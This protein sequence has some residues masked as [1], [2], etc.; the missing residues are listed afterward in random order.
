MD[1]F[2][3]IRK[4]FADLTPKRSDVTLGIGDDGAILQLAPGHELV[5]T[6]DTLVERHHFY[7]DAAP[8]DIGWKS[9]ATGL[10]D[11]AAMGADPHSC[12]LAITLPEADA[13]WLK[14]FSRGFRDLAVQHGVSLIGGNTT[15]GPA[16]ITVTCFG[17]IQAGRAVRRAG[18]KNG[19]IV[20]VTGT[21]GDAALGLR[22][23]Q[24]RMQA[25]S[26][27]RRL[28]RRKSDPPQGLDPG[29]ALTD[30]PS[31]EEL[32]FLRGRLDRPTPRVR[33]GQMLRDYA[34]AL[35]DLSDGL[36]GDLPHVLAAS[37]VGAEVWPDRLP[38]SEVF[39]RLTP[40]AYTIQLQVAGGDDYELCACLPAE[41]VN[42]VRRKLNVPL[43]IVGRV[44]ETP[45]LRLVTAE[46]KPLPLKFSGF[47]HFQ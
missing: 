35:I 40:P 7:D 13:S 1:E 3:V 19:D 23:V 16:S 4:F 12:L 9:L 43:T 15:H 21:L 14:E 39:R 26:E 44:V 24:L 18:A 47:R 42:E 5:A 37:R 8:Y 2:E 46:G 45:G 28:F 17:T 6:T 30:V 41:A 31:Q 25:E 33:A 10:S 20:C 11:L 34:H 22:T 27:Q 36:V 32:E 38:T 29:F